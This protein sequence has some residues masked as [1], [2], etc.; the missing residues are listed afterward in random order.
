[1]G[2]PI[3]GMVLRNSLL[4]AIML[5][6]CA[7]WQPGDASTPQTTL[8]KPG[9]VGVVM[10][11]D[12]VD[13][14]ITERHWQA[15][16]GWAK[17]V[18]INIG[19]DME[20]YTP[21]STRP[22]YTRLK[23]LANECAKRGIGMHVI[24]GGVPNKAAFDWQKM[25]AG[26]GFDGKKYST[27]PRSWWPSYAAW[28]ER[29]AH[30]VVKAYGKDAATKVRFQLFNEPYDR[31]EDDTVTKLLDFTMIRLLDPD[32]KIKGCPVDGPA[33]WGQADQMK[34]QIVAW[35][36][37]MA[38]F[39]DTLGRV[40]RIPL[41]CYPRG[42][43]HRSEDDL[44]SAYVNNAREMYNFATD[45]FEGHRVY[46]AEFGVSR[47]WDSRPDVFGSRTSEIAG[48]VLLDTLA[49]VR[50]FVPQITI[51]QSIDTSL[52]NQRREGCGLLDASGNPT[53]DFRTLRKIA[54]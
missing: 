18:R 27:M 21:D 8:A 34:K 26:P 53:V 25:G 38:K 7:S 9:E 16:N 29:A 6:G 45:T 13:P 17:F 42:G 14:K 35:D 24:L 22:K 23:T 11:I 10:N 51:Y 12:L 20:G 32:G 47:V 1:M 52:E 50:K 2:V 48:Q 15:A 40:D 5:V 33:L 39:P 28:Q 43:T 19:M 31:G 41:N 36:A 49:E 37:L 3:M 44:R 54:N 30:E 4:S 46:F